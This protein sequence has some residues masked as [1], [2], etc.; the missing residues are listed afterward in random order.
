MYPG[1]SGSPEN[2]RRG[3]CSDGVFSTSKSGEDP[4]EWPQ[5]AGIFIS[6]T[7]FLPIEFLKTLVVIYNKFVIEKAP[8][9]DIT[10]E[11]EAFARMLT[12][13]TTF[14]SD[15]PPAFKLFDLQMPLSTP[16]DLLTTIEGGTYLRL[17]ALHG[18]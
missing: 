9:T 6:G 7:H 4:P 18:N 5:P 10:A 1:L 8:A 14:P 17:D 2:H 15:Q 11:D 3:V 16:K 12:R 13:R